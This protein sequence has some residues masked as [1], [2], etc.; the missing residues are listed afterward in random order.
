MKRRGSPR[1]GRLERR[2]AARDSSDPLDVYLNVSLACSASFP[3]SPREPE[4]LA[5]PAADHPIVQWR[6]AT[7]GRTRADALSAF[8]EAHPRYVEADYWRG[9]YRTTMAASAIGQRAAMTLVS[10]PAARR[11]ARERMTVAL[12][13]IPRSLAIAFDLAGVTSVTSPRDALPL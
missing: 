11:E 13:A 7:C 6:L 12:A 1:A 9:R 5:A 4:T 3:V 10:D 2:L 8:A